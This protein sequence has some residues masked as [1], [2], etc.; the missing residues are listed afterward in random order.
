VFTE[1]MLSDFGVELIAAEIVFT[2]RELE[3]GVWDNK[4]Q[5][6]CFLTN[7]AITVLDFGGILAED[8]EA[9]SAAM[10]AA[11]VSVFFVGLRHDISLNSI[12]C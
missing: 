5:K 8:F 9:D 11:T 4:V 3:L 1:I 6:A 2:T 7:R 12:I 10:T